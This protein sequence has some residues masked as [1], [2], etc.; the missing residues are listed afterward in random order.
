MATLIDLMSDRRT[1]PYTIDIL[2]KN[3]KESQRLAKL[4]T[5][6]DEVYSAE[7]IADY[8]P[9]NQDEKLDVIMSMALF[10][11]PAFST[12]PIAAPS[13]KD[14]QASVN[15]FIEKLKSSSTPSHQ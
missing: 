15:R 8:V 13:L 3:L 4:L 5:A 7:T 14:Q 11:S 9:Q 1:S 2:G 10:L 12:A 6:L